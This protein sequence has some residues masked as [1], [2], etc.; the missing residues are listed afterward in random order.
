MKK[1]KIKLILFSLAFLGCTE[2]NSVKT[3]SNNSLTKPKTAVNQT[4]I[5]INPKP[6]YNCNELPTYPANY[7]VTY[8]PIDDYPVTYKAKYIESCISY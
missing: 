8:E 3:T 7:F 1:L 4:I 6:L 5:Y 2:H